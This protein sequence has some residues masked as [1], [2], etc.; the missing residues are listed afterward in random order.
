[1]CSVLVLQMVDQ[2]EAA[3]EVVA[4]AAVEAEVRLVA[5]AGA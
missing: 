1:M 3:A 4:E 5:L 2:A